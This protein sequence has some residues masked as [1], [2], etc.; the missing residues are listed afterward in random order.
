[1]T[2]EQD[3]LQQM[4]DWGY[5]TLHKPH[6]ESPGYR[7][8]LVALRKQPTGMHFDPEKINLWLRDEYGLAEQT[9]LALT[10]LLHP[11]PELRRVCPGPIVLVDRKEKRVA[12]FTFGGTLNVI[13]GSGEIVCSFRSPAPILRMTEPPQDAAARLA[14]EVETLMGG[15]HARWGAEDEGYLERLAEV[16]PFQLYIGSIH[17]ILARFEEHPM[18][19]EEDPDLYEL[20]QDEQR[21]LEETGQW[22]R[23]PPTLDSL[24]GP[25]GRPTSSSIRYQ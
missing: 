4:E 1:M 12:F 17:T 3:I 16:D 25:P 14:V 23:R 21:W 24:L 6:P 5:L 20:V 19:Q 10:P 9:S 8:L 18:L 2:E 15:V 11:S 22:P 13:F 7:Q